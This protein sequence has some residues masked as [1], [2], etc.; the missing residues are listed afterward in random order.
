MR[1][2]LQAALLLAFA[3]NAG[4][5]MAANSA[6]APVPGPLTTRWTG[7][8]TPENPLPEYPRPTMVREQWRN[9][10]GLWSYAITPREAPDRRGS[11]AKSSSPT[12]SSPRS[13]A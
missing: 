9:L 3:A 13:Q 5:T 10:N 1:R 4:R 7:L 11:T 6:W 12:R 2:F 8:V